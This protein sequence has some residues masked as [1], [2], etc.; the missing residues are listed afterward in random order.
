[1]E[2]GTEQFTTSVPLLSSGWDKAYHHCPALCPVVNPLLMRV[3]RLYGTELI[4]LK[5]IREYFYFKEETND[6][7]F[8]EERVVMLVVNFIFYGFK[9]PVSKFS[10]SSVP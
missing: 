4:F 7:Y 2:K 5:T 10:L 6:I 1:M 3:A 8:K 9:S